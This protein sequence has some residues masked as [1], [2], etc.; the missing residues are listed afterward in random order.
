M[1]RFA[2]AFILL[3]VVASCVN[4]QHN[5]YLLTADH[6][7]D[8]TYVAVKDNR[9]FLPT[10]TVL[11]DSIYFQTEYLIA[12]DDDVLDIDGEKV[13]LCLKG[14]TIASPGDT[15][16]KRREKTEYSTILEIIDSDVYIISD[17]ALSLC[18]INLVYKTNCIY[19]ESLHYFR[20]RNNMRLDFFKEENGKYYYKAPL[21]K[22]KSGFFNELDYMFVIYNHDDKRDLIGKNELHFSK[23]D[24]SVLLPSFKAY[25][26]LQ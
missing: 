2:F 22:W 15:L 20:D 8:S 18:Q 11:P 6:N 23:E 17:F 9:L 13:V 1:R 4:Q 21:K 12:Q 3:L 5:L 26:T 19:N 7:F 14:D 10:T 16:I 24:V 25:L